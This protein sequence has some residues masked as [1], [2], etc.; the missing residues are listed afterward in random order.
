VHGCFK[1]PLPALPDEVIG[2]IYVM[3]TADM[4][5]ELGTVMCFNGYYGPRYLFTTDGLFVQAV[6]P[7]SRLLP[8]TAE[9]AEAGMPVDEMSPGSEAYGGT[10]SQA[11]DGRVFLTGS[12]GG[13]ACVIIGVEGLDQIRRLPP[14]EVSVTAAQIA[15]GE[16]IHQARERARIAAGAAPERLKIKRQSRIVDGLLDEP[17]FVDEA[18]TIKADE[19]RGGQA[20]L[21]FDDDHLYVAFRVKDDTPWKNAGPDEKTIFLTGDSVDIQ[22]GLNPVAGPNRKKPWAGDV[23]IAIAPFEKDAIVMLYQPILEGHTGP[24][25]AFVSPVGRVEMDRVERLADAKVA[26]TRTPDGYDLEA[27][28]PLAGLR[29]AFPA[30]RTIS[31]DVGVLFSDETG[32]KCLLR[33]YWSNRNTNIA[34]DLPSETR[35]QP[36]EWGA[37]V[38]EP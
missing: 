16:A 25:E 19:R 4:G 32:S 10:F 31:G 21:S 23:R 33:R 24:R 36:A 11:D 38:I 13:P 22:L 29:V 15:E 2:T 8:R 35:L 18:V 28:I 14:R 17:G 9:Q 27:A 6:F 20:A 1:A 12:L 7:D 30:G 5:G 26:V 3:G 37:V 34:S